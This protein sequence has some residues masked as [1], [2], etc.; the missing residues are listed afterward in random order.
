MHSG[1]LKIKSFN[2]MIY[3]FPI[4]QFVRETGNLDN[5]SKSCL[6]KEDVEMVVSP[7]TKDEP[8]A[9]DQSCA[10]L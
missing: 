10:L 5:F 9:F 3:F 2:I 7:S 4:S 8:L 6:L 1:G